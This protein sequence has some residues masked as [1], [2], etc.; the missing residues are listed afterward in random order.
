ML[1]FSA[2]HRH[3]G[4]VSGGT[5]SWAW[6]WRLRVMVIKNYRTNYKDRSLC[7]CSDQ[8]KLVNYV[9][10]S[11]NVNI[12][13][14]KRSNPVKRQQALMKRDVS[15]LSSASG[16]VSWASDASRR[17]TS[18]QLVL[19]NLFHMFT[20]SD[21][22]QPNWGGNASGKQRDEGREEEQFELVRVL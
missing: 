14:H 6:R 1:N 4:A 19:S 17:R 15:F 8:W 20:A 13:E 3:Q 12:N 18:G 5:G 21:D 22:F 2:Q 10:L 9:C 7:F 11:T 16:V